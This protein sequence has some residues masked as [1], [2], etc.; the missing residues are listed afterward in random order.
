MGGEMGNKI[1]YGI[2]FLLIATIKLSFSMEK[3]KLSIDE[4]DRIQND[5]ITALKNKTPYKTICGEKKILSKS[6]SIREKSGKAC[7][8]ELVAAFANTQCFLSVDRE[9]YLESKCANNANAVLKDRKPQAVFKDLVSKL[10][11]ED[12][13]SVCE[14][15]LETIR[16]Y[17]HDA[18]YRWKQR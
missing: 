14:N 11:P 17:C 16:N 1:N 7:K 3:E 6:Y 2:I 18:G 13:K 8:N 15:S 4:N 12:K 10:V 5:F 9:N